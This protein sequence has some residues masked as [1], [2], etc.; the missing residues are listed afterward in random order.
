MYATEEPMLKLLAVACLLIAAA[1]AQELVR[2]RRTDGAE[3][4]LRVY[5]PSASGCAPL[6]VISPGAGGTENGYKYLGEGMAQHGWLAIVVGHKESGPQKLFSE[7]RGSGIHNGLEDMVT[8]PALYRDRFMDIGAAL[9]YAEGRCHPPFRALL[10]HSMGSIT[11]MIEAGAQNKLGLQGQNRFD[12][13]VAISPSGPGS[14]FPADA[15]HNIRKPVY[16]LTGTRDKALEGDWKT[17][18]RPFDDLPGGCKWLG[19]IDGAT[20]MDFARQGAFSNAGKLTVAT[21]SDFL[22][23]A[24]SGNC[25]LSAVPSGMTMKSK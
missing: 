13:Y 14:I 8:D 16:V 9:T 20:H 7:V 6:A 11:A 17:R 3:T 5:T 12:A 15:W 2:V 10:G 22:G 24:R 25:A 18:T 21:A 4:A 1:N 23:G 19:V